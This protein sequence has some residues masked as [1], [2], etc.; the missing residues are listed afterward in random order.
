MVER[1]HLYSEGDRPIGEHFVSC[2]PDGRFVRTLIYTGFVAPRQD[3]TQLIDHF[4][5]DIE[6]LDGVD[7][8]VC[9]GAKLVALSQGRYRRKNQIHPGI[10]A[11][12]ASR[13]GTRSKHGVGPVGHKEKLQAAIDEVGFA[14]ILCAATTSLAEKLALEIGFIHEQMGLFYR[15]AGQRVKAIDGL[16]KDDGYANHVILCPC[17]PMALCQ[18]I[19]SQTGIPVAIVDINYV[20]GD[21]L[22]VSDNS[23]LNEWEIYHA[24]ADNPFGQ[25]KER[26]PIA[27]VG[28]A[29]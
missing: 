5:P 12:V 25:R 22:G 2:S 28:R 6:S 10:F 14:R 7:K 9:L 24:L 13:F 1:L 15:I 29:E 26:T 3:L 4:V 20:G 23:P 21:I 27:I 17:D 8:T 18:D 11:S 16:G 19:T